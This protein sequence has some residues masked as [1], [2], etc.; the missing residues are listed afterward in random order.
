[1]PTAITSLTAFSIR[2]RVPGVSRIGPAVLPVS[3]VSPE[4]GASMA[5]FIHT[6]RWISLDRIAS[7]PAALQTAWNAS[8]FGLLVPSGSP[9]SIRANGP[10]CSIVPGLEM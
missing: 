2:A 4:N 3:A 8:S 6:P 7:I 5:N 1:M 9:N 10:R